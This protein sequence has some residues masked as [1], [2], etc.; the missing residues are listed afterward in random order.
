MATKGY[1]FLEIEISTP[2]DNH[3]FHLDRNTSIVR[4]QESRILTTEWYR[5]KPEVFYM[6]VLIYTLLKMLRVF[7]RIREKR[8]TC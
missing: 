8:S 1:Q 6:I 7:V 5:T 3:V 2:M 4:R